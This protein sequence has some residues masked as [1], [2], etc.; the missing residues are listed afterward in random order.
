MVSKEIPRPVVGWN[1]YIL[2][3]RTHGTV[4]WPG[5]VRDRVG[6]KAATDVVADMQEQES[7]VDRSFPW[8]GVRRLLYKVP[9]DELQ[10][11]WDGPLTK[12]AMG[13][14]WSLTGQL[15]TPVLPPGLRRGRQKAPGSTSRGMAHVIRPGLGSE[16]HMRQAL[17]LPSSFGEVGPAD[18]DVIF[19]SMDH[20]EAGAV[21]TCLA[22]QTAAGCHHALSSGGALQ[23]ALG[24]G[25][26]VDARQR[27]EKWNIA[28]IAAMVPHL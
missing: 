7:P 13:M 8:T 6:I 23:R 3:E 15:N 21:H 25:M 16:E 4:L 20:G 1:E 17:K 14:T 9:L 27:A 10:V 26:P 22:A 24:R 12:G 11:F 28:L 18:L 2:R 5:V 19:A